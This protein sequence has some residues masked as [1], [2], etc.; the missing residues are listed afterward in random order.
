MFTSF[1]FIDD[2]VGRDMQ[3]SGCEETSLELGN[4]LA[5]ASLS[6]NYTLCSLNS[7]LS[8]KNFP[9]LIPFVIHFACGRLLAVWNLKKP[10][11]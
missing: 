5:A 10:P 9:F 3:M 2:V 6:W 4:G 8:P 7:W 11:N 1:A